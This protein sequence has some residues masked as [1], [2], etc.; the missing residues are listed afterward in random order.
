[1]LCLLAATILATLIFF[2]QTKPTESRQRVSYFEAF[3]NLAWLFKDRRL[4][5]LY[6]VD[7]LLYLA[8]FGFFRCFPCTWMCYK[9]GG[10]GW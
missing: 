4:R 3:T 9:F 8:I 10:N 7:F 6:L 1:V 2:A 5:Q